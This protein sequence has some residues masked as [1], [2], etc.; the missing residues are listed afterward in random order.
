MTLIRYIPFATLHSAWRDNR[1]SVS[2]SKIF[3]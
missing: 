3:I 1:W 2:D